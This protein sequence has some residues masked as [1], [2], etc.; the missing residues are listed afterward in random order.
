MSAA[1]AS[2]TSDARLEQAALV[3]QQ[4]TIYLP[5]CPFGDLDFCPSTVPLAPR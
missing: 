2:A 5:Q 3:S 1:A 4:E